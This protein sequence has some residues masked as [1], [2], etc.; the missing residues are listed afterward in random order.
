MPPDVAGVG[1]A[2]DPVERGETGRVQCPNCC[3]L[4]LVTSR[5]M[6]LLFYRCE[7]C[8]TVGASPEPPES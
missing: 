6:G 7:L 8:E 2:A 3:R 1:D 5:S 4:A